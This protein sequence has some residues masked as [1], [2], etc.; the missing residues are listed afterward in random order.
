MPETVD[1]D[2]E[3]VTDDLY[4][5]GREAFEAGSSVLENPFP[6]S[7]HYAR[8]WLGGWLDALADRVSGTDRSPRAYARLLPRD[9]ANLF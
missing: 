7:G 5:A 9:E 2:N 6:G 1:P 8:A 3:R 4:H